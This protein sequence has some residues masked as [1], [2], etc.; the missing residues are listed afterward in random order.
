M[1]EKIDYLYFVYLFILGSI[2]GSF[3]NVVIFRLPKGLSLI[4]PGSYCPNC[5]TKIKWYENIPI[6]SYLFIKGKCTN[7][8]KSISIL[9]PIIELLTGIIFVIF[10]YNSNSIIEYI[11]FVVIAMLFLCLV[12]IDFKEYLLPDIL[13]SIIFLIGLIYFG[14]NEGLNAWPRLLYGLMTGTML[15]LLR[16]TSSLVYKKEAFGLGDVKLGALLGFLLG[17]PDALL[18]I[19]FGFVIAAFIFISLILL[20]KVSKDTYLPFGPYM[21]FGMISFL[22]CGEEIIHWYLDFFV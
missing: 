17:I 5:K 4:N 2:F 13:L 10:L 15:W 19:F 3:L 16:Y 9:Y 7:C 22:L 1:A 20:K 8:D 21:V 6:F 12:F 18:A 11:V 14:Y